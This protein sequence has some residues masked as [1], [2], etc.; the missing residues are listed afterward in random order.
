[1]KEFTDYHALERCLSR[2]CEG[3][4]PEDQ[5]K[6]LSDLLVGQLDFT[7]GNAWAYAQTVLNQHSSNS[8]ACVA[9]NAAKLTGNWLA[10]SQ[11]GLASGY[12]ESTS[13]KWDFRSDLTFE[14]RK[15]AYRGSS[16]P[17]GSG[18]SSNSPSDGFAGVWAPSDASGN[19]F[20]VITIDR[21][22]V[23]RKL[24]LKW[25]DQ[26]MVVP[27]SCRIDGRDYARS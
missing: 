26:A 16:S 25:L 20:E 9:A 24:S 13:Y 8:A 10:M 23:S 3:A 1:M 6:A 21:R 2:I 11:S 12:L 22:N 5:V 7:I 14:F 27:R 17:F 18:F 19:E 4:P 15:E